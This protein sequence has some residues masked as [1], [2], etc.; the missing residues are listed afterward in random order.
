MYR[1]SLCGRRCRPALVQA[2]AL[3][4]IMF[5]LAVAVG[6]LLFAWRKQAESKQEAQND[7]MILEQR[8]APPPLP[9]P[10][11][12]PPGQREG[13]LLV[14][15]FVSD[16][17]EQGYVITRGSW[18]HPK[19]SED[20][21]ATD[22]WVKGNPSYLELKYKLLPNLYLGH[23]FKVM[24]TRLERAWAVTQPT[25][26]AMLVRTTERGTTKRWKIELKRGSNISLVYVDGNQDQDQAVGT[27][28][29]WLLVDLQSFGDFPKDGKGLSEIVITYEGNEVTAPEG[30][31]HLARLSFINKDKW[32]QEVLKE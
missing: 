31:L 19:R 22:K 29:K 7:N 5:L 3:A 27:R 15:A 16:A 25:H 14:A 23:F 1:E 6:A 28:W 2:T 9:A 30:V 13:E 18:H 21:D 32:K 4:W 24:T 17:L 10:L 8:P 20:H 12:P 11:P 26:L